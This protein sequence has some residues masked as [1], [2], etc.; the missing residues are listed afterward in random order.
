MYTYVIYTVQIIYEVI[1]RSLRVGVSPGAK[2]YNTAIRIV[3]GYIVC[4]VYAREYSSSKVSAPVAERWIYEET[5]NNKISKN[6]HLRFLI[7]ARIDLRDIY[8]SA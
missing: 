7:Y 2:F 1:I 3:R 5:V 6:N 8:Y 4:W